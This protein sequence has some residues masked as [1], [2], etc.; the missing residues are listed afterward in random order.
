MRTEAEGAARIDPQLLVHGEFERVRGLLDAA[1]D[2]RARPI[3]AVYRASALLHRDATPGV[4][5]QV[6]ALDAARYGERELAAR[7]SAVPV[8]AAEGTGWGVAWATA[9]RVDT[10]FRYA[11]TGL[12][13]PSVATAVGD[14]RT[15][16]AAPTR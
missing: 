15:A 12:T 1:T 5:R 4:R 16:A 11:L 13:V 10:R 3:A 6:P 8:E 14:G 9:G 2:A 7:I